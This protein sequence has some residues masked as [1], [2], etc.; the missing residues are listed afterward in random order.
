MTKP[1]ADDTLTQAELKSLLSYDPNTGLFHRLTQKG[2]SRIGEIAGWNTASGYIR[3]S[4]N[5]KYFM[6]HRLAWLYMEG[7][8]PP[9]QLDHINGVRNDNR[10]ANLRL[11]THKQNNENRGLQ[12]NNTTGFRGVSYTK[13][14]GKY[15]AQVKHNG[16]TISLG[17]YKDAATAGKVAAER[18]AQI[19]THDS[20]STEHQQ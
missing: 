17:Y 6:A 8:F 18:R 1:R 15:V 10:I 2:P 11:A 9:N 7:V 3:I 5:S 12:P 16:K 14:F 4:I 19:F 20:R 13:S